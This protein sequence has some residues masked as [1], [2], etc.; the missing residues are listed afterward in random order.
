MTDNHL[1]GGM[2]MGRFS[3]IRITALLPGFFIFLFAG[4]ASL[5]FN[6]MIPPNSVISTNC[7]KGQGTVAALLRTDLPT[8]D[9]PP[10]AFAYLLPPAVVAVN[11][12]MALI[13]KPVV[14]KEGFAARRVSSPPVKSLADYS[15]QIETGT[16]QLLPTALVDDPVV[17]AFRR[18]LIKASAQSQV[19]AATAAGIPGAKEQAAEVDK[20]VVPDSVSTTQVKTFAETL[21]TRMQRPT[22]AVPSA[23]TSNGKLTTFVKYFSDFYDEKFVDRFGQ[24]IA[25]PSS[26]SLPDVPAG[27]APIKISMAVSDADI[28]SALTVLIEYLA[29][30]F[31]PTPVLGTDPFGQF[32][33]K[34]K[35]YPGG[36]NSQPTALQVGMANYK[37]IGDTCGVTERNA[38]ILRFLANAAGDEAQLVDGLVTQSVGGV[39]ISLGAFGKISIGDNQML[40]TI[41]K[42]AA[43]RAAMRITLAGSYWI[44]ESVGTNPP[45]KVP[46]PKAAAEEP[47]WSGINDVD[48]PGSGSPNC[49]IHFGP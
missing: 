27:T 31:D 1:T 44:L 42:T 24:T 41:V 12:K 49:Y 29:D 30:I 38:K 23:T 5:N 8:N 14:V 16:R 34:T 9:T 4:C 7:A 45:T 25:K 3:S 35:F 2:T 43:S 10:I 11:E 46:E 33:S 21:V 47:T 39:G 28:A 26:L 22:I 40:A 13:S 19:A 37:E 48:C 6:A 18:A 20:Y 17:N 36:N 15:E 32:S